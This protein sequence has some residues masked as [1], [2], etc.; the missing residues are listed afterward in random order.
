MT[1]R[2]KRWVFTC[3]LVSLTVCGL[4]WYG[5]LPGI[6]GANQVKA[7]SFDWTQKP[8]LWQIS[9]SNIA[10]FENITLITPTRILTKSASNDQSTLCYCHH[11]TDSSHTIIPPR[12]VDCPNT[13]LKF[14]NGQTYLQLDIPPPHALASL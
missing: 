11:N 2:G 10:F 14:I 6:D 8:P 9:Q 1:R 13:V 12:M 5:L 7:F 4:T 3:I